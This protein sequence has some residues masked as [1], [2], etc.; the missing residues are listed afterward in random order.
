MHTRGSDGALLLFYVRCAVPELVGL[1][2]CVGC[3]G[4]GERHRGG[5][6]GAGEGDGEPW[7]DYPGGDRR[8]GGEVRQ[9]G[10]EPP[11]GPGFGGLLPAPSLSLLP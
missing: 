6:R 5:K 3:E 10:E 2:I 11:A 8:G 7:L 4:G 1:V 9:G